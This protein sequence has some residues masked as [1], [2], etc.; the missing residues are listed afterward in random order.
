MLINNLSAVE[1]ADAVLLRDWTA[2]IATIPDRCALQAMRALRNRFD[3]TTN[4]GFVTV[5]GED[6][7]TPEYTKTLVTNANASPIVRG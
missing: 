4:L 1:V 6:D 7:V 5:F 3:T 2:I